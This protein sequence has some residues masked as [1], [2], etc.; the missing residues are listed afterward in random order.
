MNALDVIA[1]KRAHL[2]RLA[3]TKG[4]AG[5]IAALQSMGEWVARP[6]GSA[7]RAILHALADSGIHIKSSS[8]DAIASPDGLDFT[9]PQ[10]LRDQLA[11][12]T[13]VEIKTANQAR[14]R[15]GFAGFFFAL[16]ESEIAAAAALGERH[17]VALYNNMTGELLIT[18]VPEIIARASSTNW[19]VSVQL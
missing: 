11:T 4:A 12:A 3:N 16:T 8:F 2:Q 13:F 10:R 14:V 6:K 15:P 1:A 18:S 9:D 17:R 7:L 19:Q 5:E